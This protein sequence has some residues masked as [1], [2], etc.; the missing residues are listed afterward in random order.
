[1]QDLETSPLLS[2]RNSHAESPDLESPRL[3]SVDDER[4]VDNDVLPETSTAG[5]TIGWASA[6]VLV[7][8]RV[9]GSG[10]F[11]MPGTIVQ[12]VGSPGL[13]M[14][15][16]VIG[17]LVAWAG[18]AIDMEYGCMLPRSGGVKVYL[19]YTYR[20]PRFLTSTLVA[21]Q[22]VLLGVTASNCIVFAKYTL[23]AAN[24]SP[25]DL[26]TKLLAV[27]L[28]TLI[29]IVHSCF[30]RTGIWIQNVLGWLK[31][32]LILFMILT[33]LFVVIFR[34]DTST[35]SPKSSSGAAWDD[36]WKDSN[37]E[38]NNLSTAFFKVLYSYGGLSNINNVLNE[39]KNPVRTI[40]SVG[41]AALL[42]ACFMYVLINIAYLAVVPLEEVKRSREL[43]AALFFE[44]VFGAGFGDKFLPLAIALSAAGNVM[45]V[46]FALARVNQEVA[47][48]GFL[49]FAEILA[50]SKPF[51]SPM[52]GLIVHYVP[53]VLVIVLP[54][55]ATVYS[56]IADV[57]GYASQ[58]LALA[59]GAG[60]LI[61]R[62]RKPDLYRPFKA[63][64]PAVWL[65]IL[66]CLFLISAPLFPPKKGTADV[67]FFYATYALVGLSIY[68]FGIGY[69][70]IWTIVLPRYS[71]YRLEEEADILGDGTTITKLIRKEL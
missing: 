34:P 38:W 20:K 62:L 45:V 46:T 68:V 71:G 65:R 66:L 37:W 61:L 51:G 10:I 7:I 30:Y 3:Q 16:W 36:L 48:Q 25:G 15:L 6:Y 42:T 44:R 2:P 11:A 8:S 58:F 57:E 5:R 40:K 63:W 43:I 28:L 32:G 33:G 14:V 50:S 53:S 56:F 13:A 69:W 24:A 35:R 22:A 21:V 27:G 29:T 52:G 70:F 64:I 59:V 67:N 60:L 41:P 18:L 47:R 39:V 12:N 54:P 23:F 9:I 19:E 49:P 26:A 31:I 55:S 1:M 17:A 4:K